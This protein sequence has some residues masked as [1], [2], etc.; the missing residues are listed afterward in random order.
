MNILILTPDRVGSTLLHR[1]TSVFASFNEDPSVLTINTHELTNGLYKYFH[2]DWNQEIITKGR[3]KEQ[4]G[5][6]QPLEHAVNLLSSVSHDKISRVAHYHVKNRGDSIGD[7]LEFYNYLNNNFYIIACKR[8]NIFEHALSWGII[9]EAKTESI[10]QGNAF[11][12]EEKFKFMKEINE[13]G[14]NLNPDAFQKHLDNYAD[15]LAWIDRHFVVNA[16]FE[17]ERDVQDLEKFILSLT[18][19]NRN[20]KRPITWFEKF[21][22][23]W[24]TWNQIHYLRSLAPF[25]HDYTE[26]EKELLDSGRGAYDNA[27]Q[28]IKGLIDKRI[29]FSGIPIKLHT[30]KEKARLVNNAP[31]LLAHYNNWARLAPPSVPAIT[32]SPT[33]LEQEAQQEQLIWTPNTSNNSLGYTGQS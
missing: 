30:L 5:Y 22:I 13:H 15:Y 21:D 17:Y 2:P 11:S 9:R 24:N 25:G 26:E 10:F 7:Q 28:Y 19:F 16:Y 8:K 6:F 23:E 4:W 1:T 27:A 32:Y 14:V 12:P 20:G 18:P 3:K 33:M 29:M 31:E